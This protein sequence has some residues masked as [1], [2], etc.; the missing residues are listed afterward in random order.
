MRTACLTFLATATTIL[1]ALL[2]ARESLMSSISGVLLVLLGVSPAVGSLSTGGSHKAAR[3][4]SRGGKTARGGSRGSKA[5]RGS[6]ADERVV[7]GTL[8]DPSGVEDGCTLRVLGPQ[9]AKK[10]AAKGVRP[11]PPWRAA[12]VYR[13]VVRVCNPTTLQRVA[14]AASTKSSERSKWLARWGPFRASGC[15]RASGFCETQHACF[16]GRDGPHVFDDDGEIARSRVHD[17]G[18]GGAGPNSQRNG[19]FDVRSG[20]LVDVRTG[21]SF[22]T[23][24]RQPRRH[25]RE[26]LRRANLVLDLQGNTLVANC[27]RQRSHNPAHFIMG[28]GK[29]FVAAVDRETLLRQT[30]LSDGRPTLSMVPPIDNLVFHQCQPPHHAWDWSVAAFR[31]L[32]VPRADSSGLL[33]HGWNGTNVVWLGGDRLRFDREGRPIRNFWTSGQLN[34]D[35][36][37]V[38]VRRAYDDPRHIAAYLA[39]NARAHV[40]V[41]QR[42]VESW[43]AR[44]TRAP[45]L[46]PQ[47]VGLD[48]EPSPAADDGLSTTTSVSST[49]PSRTSTR[50][51]T[52]RRRAVGSCPWQCTQRLRVA[53]WQRMDNGSTKLRRIVNLREVSKLVSEY[54]AA[55]LR[56]V[57]ATAATS[58]IE[59]ARLWRSFDLLLSTHGSQLVSLL[60]ARRQ[61][62]VVELKAMPDLSDEAP[63]KNGPAFLAS[64][65]SSYGHLP[66][67]YPEGSQR[68]ASAAVVNRALNQTLWGCYLGG[69]TR[70]ARKAAGINCGSRQ[71]SFRIAMKDADL[72]IDMTRLRVDF[73]RAMAQ[74]CGCE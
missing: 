70:K 1:F 19:S 73:E 65:T 58:A 26:H 37:L 34:E 49:T 44:S 74:L 30:A 53:A 33:R 16:S 52:G 42:D 68:I 2:A 60:F 54:T 63:S 27:V 43:L 51:R 32:I 69:L 11:L 28:H 12:D 4:A 71:S 64:F 47:P 20:L 48:G 61:T 24:P 39:A 38:C 56:T 50:G 9:R 23:L 41:W 18:D 45:Q 8:F 31:D 46:Q 66:A 36:P 40:D 14:G 17:Y 55:P 57:S 5:A 29:L 7:K 13:A 22:L 15:R 6:A 72:L 10:L 59:Q 35:E 3:G 21:G 25:P 62:A 67:E